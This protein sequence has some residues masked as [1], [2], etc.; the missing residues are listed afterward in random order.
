MPSGEALDSAVVMGSSH[1][2]GATTDP[3]K[4]ATSRPDQATYRL[5]MS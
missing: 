5:D 3:N 4:R 2:G 1:R